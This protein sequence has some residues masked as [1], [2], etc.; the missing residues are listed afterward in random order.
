M[1]RRQQPSHSSLLSRR[2][3]ALVCILQVQQAV[4]ILHSL[5]PGQPLPEAALQQALLGFDS[6]AVALLLKDLSRAGLGQRA[7]QLFDWLRSLP[8][9]HPLAALCDVYTWT[10]MVSLCMH[11]QDAARAQGLVGDMR[12]RGV[13]PNVH[14]YTALMNVCIKC[15][16]LEAALETYQ[17]MRQEG[18]TPNVGE[19]L[20]A[21]PSPE[22]RHKWVAPSTPL[23]YQRMRREG[24][25][26]A[27]RVAGVL[28][29]ACAPAPLPFLVAVGAVWGLPRWATFYDVGLHSQ[30]HIVTASRLAFVT[31]M[32]QAQS[33]WSAEGCQVK[34]RAGAS[35]EWCMGGECEAGR[36]VVPFA[37][38][39]IIP[40]CSHIQ[41][42]HRCAWQD[43]ALGAG[44]SS[45]GHNEAG[46]G[47]L[48]PDACV[49]A[50]C[51]GLGLCSC[52]SLRWEPAVRRSAF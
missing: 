23:S 9:A 38:L 30:G 46:G 33:E 25:P 40:A 44:S 32:S 4:L 39:T 20:S 49:Q 29:V 19:W 45:G 17:R 34:P 7:A 10:A 14:T 8:G 35:S 2:Q 16:R 48:Q 37:E 6:R 27:S 1:P 18:C 13:A 42:T 47:L 15:G 41:H 43:G 3:A 50:C 5:G 36:D 28:E 22:G 21:A 26:P 31:R 11:Q 51:P 12:A 52:D 24:A